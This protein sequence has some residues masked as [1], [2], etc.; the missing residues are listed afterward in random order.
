MRSPML[1]DWR[2]DGCL[3]LAVPEDGHLAILTELQSNAVLRREHGSASACALGG[4]LHALRLE[5]A[6]DSSHDAV[7]I[8]DDSAIE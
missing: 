4:C 5:D 8:N 3:V 7:P 2:E 6:T 1:P